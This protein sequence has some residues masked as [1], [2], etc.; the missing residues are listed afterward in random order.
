[1]EKQIGILV[2]WSLK[3]GTVVALGVLTVIDL[4]FFPLHFLVPTCILQQSL[5][6]VWS[7]D[8]TNQLAEHKR[9][10]L[11]GFSS[12]RKQHQ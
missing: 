1:M 12:Y 2:R 10:I 5:R 9:D 3:R 7:V 4:S 6:S 8:D 11:L